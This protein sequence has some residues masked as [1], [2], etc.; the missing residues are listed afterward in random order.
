MSDKK[1]VEDEF[2]IY[3]TDS[4][5]DNILT[6]VENF[7]NPIYVLESGT[8]TIGTMNISES[9]SQYTC[10]VIFNL[11]VYDE[12][13]EDWKNAGTDSSIYDFIDSFDSESGKLD[14]NSADVQKYSI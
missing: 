12:T 4:C 1:S 14:V 6:V 3:Y 9:K 2:S 13:N 8:G 11:F 10:D 5:E 7:G